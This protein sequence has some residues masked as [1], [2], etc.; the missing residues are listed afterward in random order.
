LTALTKKTE[1]KHWSS[2]GFFDL[3]YGNIKDPVV[4][5]IMTA[6]HI[7]RSMQDNDRY[8]FINKD[9]ERI[10]H[11][12]DM[13]CT[14]KMGCQPGGDENEIVRFDPLEGQPAVIVIPHKPEN[15]RRY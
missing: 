1:A 15:P 5:G 6:V 11:Y 10:L 7:D 12:F 14:L 8:P 4:H 2:S 13:R 9:M 3:L